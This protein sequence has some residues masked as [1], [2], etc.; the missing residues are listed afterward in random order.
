MWFILSLFDLYYLL[1]LIAK[2]ISEELRNPST[3]QE[4]TIV[5]LGLIIIFILTVILG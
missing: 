3:E 2:I 1:S 5:Y 4:I